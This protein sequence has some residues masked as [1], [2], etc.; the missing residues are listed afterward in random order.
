[1][2]AFLWEGAL[3]LAA[4][5]AVWLLVRDAPGDVGLEPYRLGGPQSSPPPPRTA[6]AGMR[7]G[8]WPLLL[9][10]A[11]LLGGPGGPGSSHLAVL[12]T[13]QG[14]D[15]G[16]VAALMSYSGLVICVG[17]IACGQVYDRL[18]GRRG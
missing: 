11:L 13:D 1:R 4:G 3:V 2:A 17:K 5:L 12:Y 16:L 8:L 7:P 6:P 14:L 10:A 15:S 9:A 18:G